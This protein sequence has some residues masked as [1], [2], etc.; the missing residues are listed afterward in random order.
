[1]YV[2]VVIFYQKVCLNLFRVSFCD[3]WKILIIRFMKILTNIL[4]LLEAY[5][6]GPKFK[7]QLERSTGG[8]SYKIWTKNSKISMVNLSKKSRQF[9]NCFFKIQWEIYFFTFSNTDQNAR[10]C[11]K[12][13]VFNKKCSL[14]IFSQFFLIF[15]RTA[16]CIGC[17]FLHCIQC[18]KT[19]NLSYQKQH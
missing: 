5:H 15:S 19:L 14:T 6:N 9:W 13:A 3:L 16:L 1:M 2:Y 12:L 17:N 8:F 4:P 11:Q 7:C 18:P 10:N